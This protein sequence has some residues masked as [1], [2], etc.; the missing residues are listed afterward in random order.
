MAGA[1]KPENA[2]IKRA[3]RADIP[4]LKE[5]FEESGSYLAPWVFPP[6]DMVRFVSGPDHLLLVM[7]GG[8]I[9][10]YYKLSAIIRGVLQQ[11][12]LG[13][14]AFPPF[15]G[16]GY[17]SAGLVLVL[18][19]AFG[20]LM[21]HRIEANI[22]PGNERSKALVEGAGFIREGY[23]KNYLQINNVWKDHERWAISR[24]IWEKR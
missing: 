2:T 3:D 6:K 16:K 14:A 19:Y 12:F 13:Y 20:E 8:Q 18:D 1:E 22:Q 5:R 9:A 7:S 24:E 17:M 23:S 21:L 11:A 10:G 4:T 15:A